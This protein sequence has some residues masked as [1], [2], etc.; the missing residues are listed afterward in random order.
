MEQISKG[1]LQDP[2]DTYN[3]LDI[4]NKYKT[5]SPLINKIGVSYHLL[6]NILEVYRKL[7]QF[8]EILPQ[9]ASANKT[10][11]WYELSTLLS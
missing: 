1:Q 5:M 8:Y 3:H 4:Q 11:I 2:C 9:R 7:L 10:V 6:A